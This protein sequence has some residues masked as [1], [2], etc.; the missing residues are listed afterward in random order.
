MLASGERSCSFIENSSVR[1]KND[2]LGKGGLVSIS[3]RA[4]NAVWRDE[5]EPLRHLLVLPTEISSQAVPL[6]PGQVFLQVLATPESQRLNSLNVISLISVP[7]SW[8]NFVLLFA[9]PALPLLSVLDVPEC[10]RDHQV[11][12]KRM[13][14]KTRSLEIQQEDAGKISHHW[15]A[16]SLLWEA[17][18]A[19]W[20]FSM[21]NPLASPEFQES[22]T[23]VRQ[24]STSP[25][26]NC[27]NSLESRAAATSNTVA[28]LKP[29]PEPH[30]H[31]TPTEENWGSLE[32]LTL[33]T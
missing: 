1:R 32:E 10:N 7:P 31:N 6:T 29:S 16:G 33:S 26:R 21:T 9:A 27:G 22:A 3:T 15:F 20:D 14:N 5:K 30:M 19:G 23:P 28:K 13:Q 12:N 17:D 8:S 11:V 24:Q 4:S 25:A 2:V 18:R